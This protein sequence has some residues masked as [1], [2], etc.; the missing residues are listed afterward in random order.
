MSITHESIINDHPLLY[1]DLEYL[2]IDDGWLSLVNILSGILE[3]HIERLKAEGV[4]YLPTA[5]QVKEKYGGL[6]FYV[7]FASDAMQLAIDDFEKI[8]RETC[9]TCG[10]VG[11]RCYQGTWVY[12]L[13]DRCANG[14][15]F[16]ETRD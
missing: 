12:T 4:E 13:C 5:S 7:T 15:V 3:K 10:G 2:E 11:R 9:Q 16:S 1:Q 8:S 14:A 6:R